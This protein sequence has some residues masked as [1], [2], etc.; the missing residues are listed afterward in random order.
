MELRI[1]L[2]RLCPFRDEPRGK[3]IKFMAEK[4]NSIFE[5]EGVMSKL[6]LNKVVMSLQFVKV[7]SAAKN[8]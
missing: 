4:P 5:I 8:W 1:N 7:S 2:S 6:I 3:H